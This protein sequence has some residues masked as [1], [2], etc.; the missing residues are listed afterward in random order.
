MTPTEAI[1]ALE[2]ALEAYESATTGKQE[3]H[4][5]GALMMAANPG[6]LRTLLDAHAG[7]LRAL[8][9]IALIEIDRD[10]SEPDEMV[11]RGL[12]AIG[13]ARAALAT[14]TKGAAE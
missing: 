5:I 13:Y 1:A 10:T 4:A 14:N 8:R 11:E 6:V 3:A 12:S 9:Q 7:A 2:K